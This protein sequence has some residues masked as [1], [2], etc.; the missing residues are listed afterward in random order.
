MNFVIRNL[1]NL[2]KNLKRN[3]EELKQKLDNK[4]YIDELDKMRIHNVMNRME[5]NYKDTLVAID[6]MK[7]N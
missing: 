4:E 1:E 5:H 7:E 2:A 3:I 6:L